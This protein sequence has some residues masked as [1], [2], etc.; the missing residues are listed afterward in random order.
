MSHYS[1]ILIYPKK[2]N[3]NISEIPIKLN[4][5]I[6]NTGENAYIFFS[7]NVSTLIGMHLFTLTKIQHWL[8]IL[9]EEKLPVHIALLLGGGGN[10]SP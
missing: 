5:C 10:G 2:F 1:R 3:R 8:G 6:P 7:L 9:R 4:L